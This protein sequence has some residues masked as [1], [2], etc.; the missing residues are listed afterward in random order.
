MKSAPARLA[1]GKARLQ[2]AP[3][4]EAAQP[5]SD[6]T[7][8]VGGNRLTLLTEGPERLQALLSLIDG[9]E[10][11]VRLLY[12]IYRDDEA[13]EQVYAAIARA[14]GRGVSVSLLIDGFGAHVRDNFFTPL[15][16]RGLRYCRF[17][18]TF[19]RRYLLR[20]HQ[21][22]ALADDRKAMIG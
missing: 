9:A 2:T 18:P 10:R 22:L 3:M 13:G 7:V 11:S 14:I 19:G 20:C 6:R 1:S 5:S 21:K 16:E 17:N 4:A 15:V 12:Y 8:E